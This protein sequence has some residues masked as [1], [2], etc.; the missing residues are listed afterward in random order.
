MLE[1]EKVKSRI[2]KFFH[3]LHSWNYRPK[4]WDTSLHYRLRPILHFVL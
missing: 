4:T 1:K 2:Q 3:S